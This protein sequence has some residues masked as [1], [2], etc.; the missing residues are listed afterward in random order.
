MGIDSLSIRDLFMPFPFTDN[1][2]EYKYENF[3]L[4]FILFWTDKFYGNNET[5]MKWMNNTLDKK[6]IRPGGR[7]KNYYPDIEVAIFRT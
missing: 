3:L 5:G 7:K 1:L 4:G 6:L 2:E